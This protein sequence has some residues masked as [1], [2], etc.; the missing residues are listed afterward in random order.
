M[1]KP[2]DPRKSPDQ[3]SAAG[4]AGRSGETPFERAWEELDT[5]VGSLIRRLSGDAAEKASPADPAELAHQVRSRLAEVHDHVQER[6]RR[7]ASVRSQQDEFLSVVA[8][9]LRTPLV[10]IQGFAQLLLSGSSLGERERLY[11]ERILQGVRA[12][13]RLVEDLRT[14]RRLE[15]GALSLE[16]MA[17]APE[18]FAV[19]L[20]EMHREEARQ[21]EVQIHLEAAPALPRLWCDP[22]RLGQALGNLVQNAVKF[23][24]RGSRIV[25]R[26]QPVGESLRFEVT[27]EGPGIDETFLPE[28]F[29]RFAQG[30]PPAEGA[31]KGFGLGLHICREIVL[32]HGGQ[33]GARNQPHGGSCFWVEV[34]LT[35]TESDSNLSGPGEER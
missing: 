31:G 27:D 20:V 4:G 32:L 24:P 8:H 21:K 28:L 5:L 15:Q 17:V 16:P 6:D 11:V 12:M 13:S 23:S 10:A 14:A 1:G 19:D 29:E 2:G 26:L 25:L 33:V 3:P 35:G 9:D 34:P 22:E 30:K 18:E 7:F